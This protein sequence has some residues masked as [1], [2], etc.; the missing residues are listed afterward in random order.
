MYKRCNVLLNTGAQISLICNNTA[1][2]LGL[3]GKD[4]SVTITKVGG[5][6]EVM[7]M[8][9]YRIPVNVLDNTRKYSVKAIGTLSIGDDITAVQTSKLADILCVPKEKI[10][11][12]KGQIDIL[13]GIDHAHIH[14]D[15]TKQVGQIVARNTPQGWV[16]F[17]G[18]TE[19]FPS[20]SRILFVTHSMP[21]DLTDFWTTGTIGVK[22]KPC[23]CDKLTSCMRQAES[24]GKGG[25]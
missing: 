23:V 17:G 10:H 25:G 1:E 14:T 9:E 6:E 5:E 8:E 12:G 11:R 13:I 19:T 16:V 7:K 21:V 15:H 3:K 22:V 2:L 20:S 18:S 4:T 24:S